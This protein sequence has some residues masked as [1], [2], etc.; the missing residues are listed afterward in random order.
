MLAE[1]RKTCD[2]GSYLAL[3]AGQCDVDESAGVDQS[4]LS[5][6]LGLLGLFHVLID[7]MLQAWFG[8]GG[9][10][11]SLACRPWGWRP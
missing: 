2:N 8:T 5:T 9:T 10:V 3:A 6:A 11:P 1:L 4:L 7:E